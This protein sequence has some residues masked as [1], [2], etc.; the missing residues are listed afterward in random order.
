MAELLAQ[1]A[2]DRKMVLAVAACIGNCFGVSLLTQVLL[3]TGATT[4]RTEELI[5][6]ELL[7]C[8]DSG[9]LLQLTPDTFQFAHDNIQFAAYELHSLAKQMELHLRIG[10]VLLARSLLGIDADQ[11]QLVYEIV[12]HLNRSSSLMEQEEEK[13]QLVR[14]NS[15]AVQRSK[16]QTAYETAVAFCESAIAI[17]E[18]C[19]FAC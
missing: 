19:I 15:K 8:K 7:A 2:H 1:Q 13:L 11:E 14:L 6:A 10:R 18:V 17:L 5:V 12:G 9:F 16:R 4:T 3:E